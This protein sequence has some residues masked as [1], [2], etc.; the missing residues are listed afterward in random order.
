M[1]YVESKRK[2]EKVVSGQ[3]WWPQQQA[4][5]SWMAWLPLCLEWLQM[6]LCAISH[7]NAGSHL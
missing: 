7:S 3:R 6:G 5:A 4:A 1:N 2:L